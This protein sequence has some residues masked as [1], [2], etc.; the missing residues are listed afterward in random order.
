MINLRRLGR[1]G[2]EHDLVVLVVDEATGSTHVVG[3]TRTPLGATPAMGVET[4]SRGHLSTFRMASGQGP[5]GCY[6][7][8]AGPL[9]YDK[10]RALTSP[11]TTGELADAGKR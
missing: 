7:H 10:T 8:P 9:S 3:E 4:R 11:D 6:R 2:R 5:R 1:R